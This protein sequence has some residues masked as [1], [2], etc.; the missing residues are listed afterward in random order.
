[1]FSSV[2]SYSRSAVVLFVED[3]VVGHPLGEFVVGPEGVG[4]LAVPVD[5]D[6]EAIDVADRPVVVALHH[7][8]GVVAVA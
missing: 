5:P 3:R 4:D 2:A 1:M 6:R 7:H 8:V